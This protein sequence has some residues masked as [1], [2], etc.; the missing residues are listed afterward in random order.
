MCVRARQRACVSWCKLTKAQFTPFPRTK[1][2]VQY[3]AHR[4]YYS[5]TSPLHTP[6]VA[7]THWLHQVCI[8]TFD[9]AAKKFSSQKKALYHVRA[10]LEEELSMLQEKQ[11]CAV[12]DFSASEEALLQ[13]GVEFVHPVDEYKVPELLCPRSCLDVVFVNVAWRVRGGST[14]FVVPLPV[15]APLSV[16]LFLHLLCPLRRR[17]A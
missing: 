9:A 5:V 2:R 4:L 15:P 7:G 10:E 11:Q 3:T 17:I 8:E 1:Q 14:S 12:R 6:K 16:P 13:A